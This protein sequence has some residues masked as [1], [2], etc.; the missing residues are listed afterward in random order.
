MTRPIYQVSGRPEAYEIWGEVTH[1]QARAIAA[2]IVRQASAHFPH[3]EF[4]IS[5]TWSMHGQ[6]LNQVAAYI[7]KHWQRWAA[8]VLN[9]AREPLSA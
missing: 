4:R 3:V 8:G 1:E 5:D 9:E 2:V 6:G 7:E